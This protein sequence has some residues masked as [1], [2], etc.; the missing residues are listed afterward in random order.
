ML[1]EVQFSQ[2]IRLRGPLP[3]PAFPNARRHILAYIAIRLLADII[4]K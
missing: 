3:R 2:L 4:R 1:I